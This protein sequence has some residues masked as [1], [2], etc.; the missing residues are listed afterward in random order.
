MVRGD[1]FFL[2]W[3]QVFFIVSQLYII[4]NAEMYLKNFLRKHIS[5]LV[6]TEQAYPDV[7]I[8]FNN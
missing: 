6:L 2:N 7:I 8:V 3:F 5:N 1:I 4:T